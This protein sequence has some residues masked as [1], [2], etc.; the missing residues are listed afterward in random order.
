M[1]NIFN[2]LLHYPSEM[3]ASV[4]AIKHNKA[5]DKYVYILNTDIKE[6]NT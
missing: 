6:L 1:F 3:E 2:I 5:Y 4:N